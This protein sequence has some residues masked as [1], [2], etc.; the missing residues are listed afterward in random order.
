[1]NL[2]QEMRRNPIQENI[3]F[4]GDLIE[5]ISPIDNIFW[6]FLV[7]FAVSQKLPFPKN[8]SD[9]IFSTILHG[10]IIFRRYVR[11]SRLCGISNDTLGLL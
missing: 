5:T 1:M 8:S 2:V 6:Q 9:T 10:K 7:D 4:Y 11:V 3:F